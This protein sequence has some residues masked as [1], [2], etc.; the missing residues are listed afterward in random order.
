MEE[1]P[2]I[3]PIQIGPTARHHNRQHKKRSPVNRFF[4]RNTRPVIFVLAFVLIGA[5]FIIYGYAASPNTAPIKGVAGK[6]LDNKANRV[7]K[8]NAIQLFDCNGGRAQQWSMP[9]NGTIQLGSSGYC[10]DVK[11]AGTK[12][13]TPVW[14]WPCNGTV[15][16]QWK[17]TA[18]GAL[19]NP[20]SGLCLDDKYAKSQN[21]NPIWMYPCNGTVAQKWTFTQSVTPKP[22]P[23][24]APTPTPTPTQPVPA[25][26][27]TPV[28]P[29]ASSAFCGTI[30]STSNVRPTAANT[31]VP[32]GTSLSTTPPAGV[33]LT[34]DGSWK[35]TADGTVID[36]KDIQN[37]WVDI[38]AKNVTIKNSRITVPQG[39]LWAIYNENN[40]P[41]LVIRNSEVTSRGGANTGIVAADNTTVCGVNAH[42]FENIGSIQG[43]NVVFQSNYFHINQADPASKDPHNDVLEI[44]VGSNIKILGNNLMQTNPDES[45]QHNT[46]ALYA[47]ATYGTLDQLVVDGN[48]FGG[49]TYTTY[50]TVVNIGNPVRL[51]TVD[52]TNNKWYLGS[53]AYGPVDALTGWKPHTWSNNTFAENGKAVNY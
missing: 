19:L 34:A 33:T 47:A 15:A 39:T 41:G 46:S 24:P 11:Y 42:G 6:C 3:E 12:P 36:G 8:G 9:G 27:P 16:Q 49:G 38:E 23:T 28:P 37:K 17:Q 25:P 40:K 31:G 48:W 43:N 4:S 44:R 29:S 2:S 14:L 13:K 50:F 21:G 26:S 1:L 22:V 30:P 52:V 53:Y 20:N 35:V 32:A 10:L 5:I 45:W 7:K 18:D 51:G